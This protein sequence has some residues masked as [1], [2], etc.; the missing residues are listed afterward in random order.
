M[1]K[2]LTPVTKSLLTLLNNI[3]ELIVKSNNRKDAKQVM[4]A[5][6]LYAHSKNVSYPVDKVDDFLDVL[7]DARPE[8]LSFLVKDIAGDVIQSSRN[9]SNK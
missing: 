3:D 8:T 6:A 1:P 4:T 5:F 7:L 2:E 9:D